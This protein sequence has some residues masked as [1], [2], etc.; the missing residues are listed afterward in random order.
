MFLLQFLYTYVCM[1][2]VW[3]QAIDS[4]FSERGGGE[5]IIG[6]FERLVG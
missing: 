3:G 6:V 2:T 4:L 1:A 5:G